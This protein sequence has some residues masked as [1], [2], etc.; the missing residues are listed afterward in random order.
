MRESAPS[1]VASDI[2]AGPGFIPFGLRLVVKFGGSL[3]RDTALAARVARELVAA[4]ADMP[5][6]IIPG[7]GPTDKLIEAIA[8]EVGLPDPAINPACM[9]AMDQT[10]ILLSA[11]NAGLAPVEDLAA[12]RPALAGGSVPVLLPSRMILGI[13]VFTRESIITSDTLAAYFAFLLGAELVVVLTD[14]DGIFEHVEDGRTEGLISECD[15]ADLERLGATSV[16]QCFGP[17]LRAV[18]MPAWVLNGHHP[19]RLKELVTG[20]RPVGT[21]VVPAS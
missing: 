11:L 17:F 21:R 13:D 8:H 6:A 1:T 20:G 19:E 12:I 5:L 2:Y 14:V 10:G 3:L 7:G 16:D 15:T 4:H 9:R 18:R